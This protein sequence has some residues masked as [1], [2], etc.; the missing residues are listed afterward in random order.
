MYI[1]HAKNLITGAQHIEYT[2]FNKKDARKYILLNTVS[3]AL[4]G[5]SLRIEKASN[6]PQGVLNA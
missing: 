1:V 2:T 4:G 3:A 5:Y 6:N